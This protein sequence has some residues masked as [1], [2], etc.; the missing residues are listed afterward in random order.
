MRDVFIVSAVRTPIGKFGGGFVDVSP[1]DLAAHAMKSAL[2]RGNV[3]P[4][5]L[6]LYIFGNIL[7]AGH[8]QLLPRQAAVKAGIPWE[9]DGY[10]LDMLC[11]SGMMATMNGI[12]SIKVGESDMI[13]TG[14]VESM[15]QAGF[16]IS[17]KARW[18][19]KIIMGK[20]EPF[21]DD[22]WDD[23]LTDTITNEGMGEQTERVAAEYEM[24]REELDN[25]AY[26][27]HARA[28]EATEKGIFAREIAPV[29]I[30]KRKK[31]VVIDKDEGVLPDTT[32]DTLGK[33]RPAFKKDGML[34]AGNSSQISDGA[35]ALILASEDAV[36]K[37]GLTPLAKFTGSAWTSLEN[38][39]FTSA[40]VPAVQK[41]LAKTGE[42][43]DDF[44]V[45]ENN[46]AFAV[47]SVLFNKV[48]GIPYEKMNIHGGAIAMG[49]PVGCSGA[50]IIVTLI[51]ALKERDGKKGFASLCHGTGGGTV[52]G[53]ELVN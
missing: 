46:E 47:N 21:R 48:L 2:E 5:N 33:L 52:V 20:S 44:D 22:L 39:K 31:T 18:G 4:E 37:Y 41:M 17:H 45:I 42:S 53:L 23:G 36:N 10:A 49:H 43:V 1:V 19:Y 38:W 51:N 40:P 15:S 16:G 12:N 29:E 8:G 27:S 9:V 35:A 3:N 13:L 14:G 32:P 25:V 7:K 26:M 24:T 28:A 30:Q 6:D 50:R 11:S 34:T